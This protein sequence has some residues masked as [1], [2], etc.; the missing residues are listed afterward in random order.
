MEY[1]LSETRGPGLEAGRWDT[2]AVFP[3]TAPGASSRP[4]ALQTP[5]WLVPRPRKAMKV[6][7]TMAGPSLVLQAAAELAPAPLPSPA[8]S[9][10]AEGLQLILEGLVV[11]GPVVLG[12]TEGRVLWEEL[13]V[14]A[15]EDIHL[16]IVEAGVVVGGPVS[17]PNET[18]HA[19]P[20][21]R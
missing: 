4:S 12:L 9:L 5:G 14:A 18:A 13:L 19:G 11:H 10:E 8:S 6:V 3:W 17:F 15:F 1:G 21:L 7:G 16:R 2:L 20:T